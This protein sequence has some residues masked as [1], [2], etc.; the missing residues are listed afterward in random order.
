MTDAQNITESQSQQLN[1]AT[2]GLASP[3]PRVIVVIATGWGP[4]YG[5][6]NS[7]SFDFCFALGRILRGAVRVICLTTNVDDLNRARARTDHVEIF[8]LLEIR[9]GSEHEF[10][11]N[12]QDLL[13]Q[14]GITDIALVFGHD[15]VTGFAPIEL[16]ALMG[17]K[18]ALF[19]HMSYIQYQG[20]KKDG[21]SAIQMDAVQ[22]DVLGKADYV[23]AVGPLLKRSAQRLLQRDVPM[24]VPGMATIRPITHRASNDFRAITFGRM[25]GEDDPIKQGSLAVAGYGRY[26]KHAHEKR[27]ERTHV[28][29]MY[30]LSQDEYKD[31]EQTVK[32]QMRREAGREIPVNATTYS[33]D[34]EDLFP[35]LADNEVALM[36]SWHEGFGLTGWEAIAA[37]VPL[38]LSKQTGL[39]R[40][41]DAPGDLSLTANVSVVDV[42]GS[43]GGVP[44]DADVGDVADALFQIS[45]NWEKFHQKAITL[46][47]HL[48]K[49]YTWEKC[50]SAT[51]DACAFPIAQ[52]DSE[53]ASPSKGLLAPWAATRPKSGLHALVVLI[54]LAAVIS[55]ILILPRFI[56]TTGGR[57]NGGSEAINPVPPVTFTCFLADGSESK[58]SLF[59]LQCIGGRADGCIHLVATQ[60]EDMM[61]TGST[62]V[63]VVSCEEYR[64]LPPDALDKVSNSSPKTDG[65]GYNFVYVPTDKHRVEVAAIS[66]YELRAANRTLAL[67]HVGEVELGT[68]QELIEKGEVTANGKAEKVLYLRNGPGNHRRVELAPVKC[69]DGP[70]ANKY[71]PVLLEPEKEVVI[72]AVLWPCL[73]LA[74]RPPTDSRL[75]SSRLRDWNAPS[76]VAH[77][78]WYRLVKR[79]GG[80]VEAHYEFH[81]DAEQYVAKHR[82]PLAQK[83]PFLLKELEDLK[84][85]MSEDIAL[86]RKDHAAKNIQAGAAKVGQERY[87]SVLAKHNVT[88]EHLIEILTGASTYKGIQ[89]TQRVLEE[90]EKAV[91]N[92]LA[93]HDQRDLPQDVP[94]KNVY[95]SRMKKLAQF[96]TDSNRDFPS[97][98]SALDDEA[99]R[100]LRKQLRATAYEP[101]PIKDD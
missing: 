94:I 30:G 66:V 35:A 72:C 10:A 83:L 51:L 67:F 87:A 7:F 75:L 55:A 17:G 71:V 4:L 46:R 49:K 47:E 82:H 43:D 79:E 34:R 64:H 95:R 62:L 53:T 28:F 60:P 86:V 20:L 15:V 22:K 73:D 88:I 21:R 63:W 85:Q 6:I 41:L 69:A 14:N 93:W 9:P 59:P 57:G 100:L 98:Y 61:R 27:M 101:W 89:D 56:G 65:P 74:P 92:F 37:G 84:R 40:L 97:E 32:E 25:S 11:S 77:L 80:T 42:R 5:G 99:Q 2:P 58:R 68:Y 16:V 81:A 8:N 29:T 31:E 13:N 39:Y 36:L 12:A 50:A 24:V 96:L 78:S 19:H 3:P 38:V 54:I 70:T 45:T 23:I 48:A 52:T 33:N 91:D 26:V 18:S 90:E 44:D 76:H 1:G